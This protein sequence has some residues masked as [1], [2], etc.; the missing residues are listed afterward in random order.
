MCTGCIPKHR[1][2]V[3]WNDVFGITF[4][5]LVGVGVTLTLFCASKFLELVI[6]NNSIALNTFCVS[7]S[8]VRS[9]NVVAQSISIIFFFLIFGFKHYFFK[10]LIQY[11]LRV[12]LCHKI[13]VQYCIICIE[14]ALTPI[15]SKTF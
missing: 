3:R 15:L 14:F 5:I 2:Y 1:E 9:G 13:P 12:N 11:K 8:T 10:Q 4:A 6:L 7:V